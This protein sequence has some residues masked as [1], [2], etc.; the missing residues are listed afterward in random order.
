MVRRV[1]LGSGVPLVGPQEELRYLSAYTTRGFPSSPGWEAK[2]GISGFI[3]TNKQTNKTK[4]KDSD[5]SG[6][7]TCANLMIC[8]VPLMPKTQM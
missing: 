4:K 3:P 8:Q 5:S 6:S 1:V 2:Y 7:Y